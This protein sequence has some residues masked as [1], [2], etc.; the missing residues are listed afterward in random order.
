MVGFSEL[1]RFLIF[2]DISVKLNTSEIDWRWID[3]FKR[4]FEELW[5]NLQELNLNKISGS[6]GRND[7]GSYVGEIE[8]LPS[9]HRLK[10][11]YVDYRHFYLEKEDVNFEK[12]TKYLATITDSQEY[13]LYLKS[14]RKGNVSFVESA[15]FEYKDRRIQASVLLKI[16]F[17]AELFHNDA[18]M[19]LLKNDIDNMFRSETL[20]SLL[21]M[22]VYER[23][24]KIKDVY[25]S[26]SQLNKNNF[27]LQM[28]VFE[29]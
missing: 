23:I 18:E 21:F 2:Q 29:E 7:D 14:L 1:N 8:C 19:I 27:V 4:R 12:F 17:N 6:F 25:W 22:I 26:V 20:R 28:P 9:F 3:L 24:L 13:R 5:D 15:F 10:G 16:F 11:L